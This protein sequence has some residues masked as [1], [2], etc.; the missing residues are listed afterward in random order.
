MKVFITIENQDAAKQLLPVVLKYPWSLDSQFYLIHVVHP[1]LVN[2]YWSLL[3]SPLTEGLIEQRRKD[4][5]A[6]VRNFSLKLQ[7][8]WHSPNIHEIVI[9]GDPATEVMDQVHQHD[10]DVVVIGSHH[11]K[12]IRSLGSVSRSILVQTPSNVIVVPLTEDTHKHLTGE[13]RL[14]AVGETLSE[15]NS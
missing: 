6:L 5:K 10:P 3:P 2:S 8:V 4:G 11:K 12:G 9:E 15:S 1:V 14:A 7:E 13:P